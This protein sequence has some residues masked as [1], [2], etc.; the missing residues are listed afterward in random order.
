MVHRFIYIHP[1]SRSAVIKQG[2]RFFI[3]KRQVFYQNAAYAESLVISD[4]LAFVLQ[5]FLYY[6]APQDM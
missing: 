4:K 1:S 5:H 3:L 2:A 6:H